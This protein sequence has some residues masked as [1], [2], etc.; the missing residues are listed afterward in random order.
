MNE[1]SIE[2]GT[3]PSDAKRRLFASRDRNP[4]S[5]TPAGLD[6]PAN[7]SQ[8]KQDGPRAMRSTFVEDFT[9]EHS[10]SIEISDSY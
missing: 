6:D 3:V 8:I 1:I 7:P 4:H 5:F 9:G 2:N 10:T